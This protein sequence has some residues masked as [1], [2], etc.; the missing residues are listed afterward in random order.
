MCVLFRSLNL[1]SRSLSEGVT[2][3][4][5]RPRRSVQMRFVSL[6]SLNGRPCCRKAP[7]FHVKRCSH[8]RPRSLR[9]R[10]ESKREPPVSDGVVS[11]RF[12]PLAQRAARPSNGA[13]VHV[14][15]NAD[16]WC[17]TSERAESRWLGD[18]EA[19]VGNEAEHVAVRSFSLRSLNQRR[20]YRM[21]VCVSRE[22]ADRLAVRA[23]MIRSSLVARRSSLVARR[24]SLVA[25]RER[26]A[27]FE[28]ESEDP[29]G[30][31]LSRC[32]CSTNRDKCTCRKNIDTP[33]FT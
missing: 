3:V 1:R 14:K 6:R 16:R 19:R 20:G 23:S 15:Q 27:R 7:A 30:G 22:T 5:T 4:E 10:S 28:S 29:G 32:A 13:C 2:R 17:R 24:S 11:S 31:V 18:R 21:E 8:S 12:A 26:G 9:A 33:R 25:C